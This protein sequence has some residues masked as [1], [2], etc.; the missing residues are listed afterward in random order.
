MF[1]IAITVTQNKRIMNTFNNEGPKRGTLNR[2]A[3]IMGRPI[4]PLRS[5]S[6]YIINCLLYNDRNIHDK[7]IIILENAFLEK[8]KSRR[9]SRYLLIIHPNLF[10]VR[11]L[12]A[13]YHP[14]T[15][16][17]FSILHHSKS[18]SFSNIDNF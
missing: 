9:W 1:F 2:Q 5:D 6:I 10:T 11:H 3:E 4:D 18:S 17:F 16:S 12:L 13:L 14:T 7:F 15:S 8:L